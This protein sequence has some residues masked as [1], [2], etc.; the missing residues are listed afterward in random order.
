MQ[1][2]ASGFVRGQSCWSCRADWG[3]DE[4]ETILDLRQGATVCGS[5][6]GGLAGTLN[7][8]LDPGPA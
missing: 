5:R 3:K 4:A 1:F 8:N 2:S 6:F 7:L